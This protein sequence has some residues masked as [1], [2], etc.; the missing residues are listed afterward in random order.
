[1]GENQIAAK[2]PKYEDYLGKYNTPEETVAA[3]T[4]GIKETLETNYNNSTGGKMR[5]SSSGVEIKASN[6][7]EIENGSGETSEIDIE[8][9]INIDKE[10]VA[11]YS[12]DTTNQATLSNLIISASGI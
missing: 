9:G 2:F 11:I 3:Y 4:G 1:M 7:I 10:A 8:N 6:K 5:L 12:K